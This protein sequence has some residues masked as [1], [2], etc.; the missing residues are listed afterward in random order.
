MGRS[1]TNQ[2]RARSLAG[3]RLVPPELDDGLRRFVDADPEQ[4][5]SIRRQLGD[6]LAQ[7]R[8]LGGAPPAPG[9]PEVDQH[10]PAGVGRQ[11]IL[12][13]VQP[14]ADHLRQCTPD[15]RVPD[16]VDQARLRRREGRRERCEGIARLLRRGER[17]LLHPGAQTG[18]RLESAP[19]PR[20]ADAGLRPEA[21]GGP[22]QADP[23]VVPRHG[24][25]GRVG[26]VRRHLLEE[27]VDLP[28]H[29][30]PVRRER[31]TGVQLHHDARPLLEAGRVG[32]QRPR[33]HG[34]V[35][36]RVRFGVRVRHEEPRRL[37]H[38][39]LR[40][41]RLHD[42]R[43]RRYGAADFR[44]LGPRIL[45]PAPLLLGRDVREGELRFEIRPGPPSLEILLHHRPVGT[46]V[47]RQRQPRRPERERA[48]AWRRNGGGAAG[49]RQSPDA[50]L[51]PVAGAV[52]NQIRRRRRNDQARPQDVQRRRDQQQQHG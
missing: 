44:T 19:P 26:S 41:A 20:F 28:R 23:N 51:Q 22:H 36:V 17:L 12:G 30:L 6:Q 29:R 40:T 46:D 31:P 38:P 33:P 18:R 32:G 13:P 43:R 1:R 47:A 9:S 4:D 35:P 2:R 49:E 34:H 52:G 39:F 11:A 45:P 24:A 42:R 48:A 5:E 3:H 37:D 15:G 16:A 27:S 25:H 7:R 50:A 10:H 14:R 8:Q 21:V